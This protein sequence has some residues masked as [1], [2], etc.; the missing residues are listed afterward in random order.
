VRSWIIPNEG[1]LWLSKNKSENTVYVYITN[2]PDWARGDRKKFLLKTVKATSGTKISVLG[3]TGNII[4]YMPQKDGKPYF[5][6]TPDGLEF[7]VV[8]SQRMYTNSQW[9]NPIVVKLENVE[10]AFTLANFKT[11]RAVSSDSSVIFKS[12]I[13]KLGDC[14]V[15][16]IGFEYRPASSR[17]GDS[18][19]W[20]STGFYAI[21]STGN[22]EIE[23]EKDKN[24]ILSGAYEYR[25]VL[26]QDGL[27][28]PGLSV[29]ARGEFV[30][31]E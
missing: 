10:P 14:K 28:T 11:L 9:P 31:P 22:Y 19:K 26:I 3:Q 24:S 17:S 29:I 6:Q 30:S 8:K 16:K 20:T 5:H 13:E 25:A 18:E 23:L 7:D 2:N 12:Q 4:E 21:S 15:Y 27:R 1:D